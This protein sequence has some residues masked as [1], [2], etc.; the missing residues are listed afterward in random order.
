MTVTGADRNL[1]TF[2]R[3]QECPA[4]STVSMSIVM[5]TTTISN[6]GVEKN[7]FHRVNVEH[8]T[9]TRQ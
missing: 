3:K 7:N 4:A 5:M 8:E 1:K 6:D 2:N 9:S